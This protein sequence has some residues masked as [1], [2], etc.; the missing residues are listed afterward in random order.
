MLGEQSPKRLFQVRGK[1]Y[2]LLVNCIPPEVGPAVIVNCSVQKHTSFVDFRV[3]AWSRRTRLRV[4]LFGSMRASTGCEKG[5]GLGREHECAGSGTHNG[6]QA[7]ALQSAVTT[8]QV[9][10]GAR[11][12]LLQLM[13]SAHF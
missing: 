12:L 1:L 4:L 7:D 2:E 5:S 10:A 9:K 3:Q 8:R 11:L 6:W 13:R